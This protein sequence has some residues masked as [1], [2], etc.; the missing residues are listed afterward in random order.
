MAGALPPVVATLVADSKQFS[1]DMDK[2]K[3]KMAE[4]SDSGSSGFSKLSSIGKTALFGIAAASAVVGAAAID[5]GDKQ[6]AA[7][8]GSRPRSRPPGSRG[9]PCRT[10]STRPAAR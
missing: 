3:A 10:R 7:Q 5:F 1:A 8:A 4:V 6:E 2:A 9:S